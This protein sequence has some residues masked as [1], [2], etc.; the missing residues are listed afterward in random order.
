MQ[1]KEALGVKTGT[2]PAPRK[3]SRHYTRDELTKIHENAEDLCRRSQADVVVY[4]DER[5]TI[6]TRVVRY[7]KSMFKSKFI[8]KTFL[9]S[10][11]KLIPKEKKYGKKQKKS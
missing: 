4:S 11:I 1:T 10:E 7:A 8:L 2:L 6:S 5:E 9:W 3:P